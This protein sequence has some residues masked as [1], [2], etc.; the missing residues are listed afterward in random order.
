MPNALATARGRAER[1]DDAD[2]LGHVRSRFSLPEGLVYLDGNSL[3]ALPAHVPAAVEDVVRRQWGEALIASWDTADWWDAPARVGA[4]IARLVGAAPEEVLVADSTSVNL[5]KV[6]V[7]AARLRPGRRTVLVES[8][9]FPTDLYV[10]GGVAGLLDLTVRPVAP[11]ELGDALDEDVA[12]VLLSQVDYRTGEAYDVAALTAAVHEAGALMVWDLSHS[13]GVLPIGFDQHGVDFAVGATYKYLNGGPGSPAFVVA[14]ARL[15][16]G[17][18]SPL[19]GW[20]GHAHPFAMAGTFEPAPGMTRLRVGT[21]PVVSLLVLEA[22]LAVFDDLDMHA[23]RARSLSLTELFST[24]PTPRWCL[25]ATPS[26]RRGHSTGE[27]ARSRCATPRPAAWCGPSPTAG[28]CAT[29][30]SLTWC[31]SASR[32]CMCV[33]LTW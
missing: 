24:S 1:L 6:L 27:A 14:A 11:H 16:D 3:G 32:R 29:S 25:P 9:T 7:A 22:A 23:V 33:T 28:W 12:V 17:L 31:G 30:G 19:T 21:P 26:R 20:N 5:F 4:R 10:A 8:G 2:P 18:A 15:Q 13:A